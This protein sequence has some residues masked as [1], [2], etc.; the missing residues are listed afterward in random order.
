[1]AVP[2]IK[3]VLLEIVALV[4]SPTN[5]WPVVVNVRFPVETLIDAALSVVPLNVR[6]AVPPNAPEL[7]YWTVVNPPPGVPPPPVGALDIQMLP[8]LVRTFPVVPGSTKLIVGVVPP[9]DR[10]G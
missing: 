8:L 6:L 9:V 7:L 10:I 3:L 5:F 4:K 2:V 1:M